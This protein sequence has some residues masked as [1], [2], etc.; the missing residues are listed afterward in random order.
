[1]SKYAAKRSLLTTLAEIAVPRL[2][3][4]ALNTIYAFFRQKRKRESL[5]FYGII[6]PTSFE[7]RHSGPQN[8]EPDYILNK[9]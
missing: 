5:S 6:V 1:V 2:Y 9:I 4:I 3:R 7:F 8:D